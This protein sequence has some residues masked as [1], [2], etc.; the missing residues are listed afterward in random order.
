MDDDSE[1]IYTSDYFTQKIFK[2]PCKTRNITLADWAAWYDCAGKPY[3]KQTDEVNVDGLL[4]ENFINDNQS[5]RIIIMWAKAV[6]NVFT[7]SS[8]VLPYCFGF[9]FNRVSFP[10]WKR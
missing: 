8:F 7:R 5:D 1:K 2:V 4:L 3:V 10:T 9:F 6:G